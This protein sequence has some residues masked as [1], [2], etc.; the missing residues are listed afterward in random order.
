MQLAEVHPLPSVRQEVTKQ[1]VESAISHSVS[2]E[3]RWLEKF[4]AIDFDERSKALVRQRLAEP[5]DRAG[6]DVSRAQGSRRGDHPW[7]HRYRAG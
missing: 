6:G 4:T 1:L 3:L 5:E 7:V 2:G